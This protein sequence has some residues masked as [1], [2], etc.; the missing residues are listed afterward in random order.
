LNSTWNCQLIKRFGLVLACCALSLSVTG[1]SA[2]SGGPQAVPLP[3]PIAPPQD[4][5]YPGVIHLDV[6]ATDIDRHIFHVRQSLPVAAGERLTLMYPE[7]LAAK[8][9]DYG[10]VENLGGLKIYANDVRLAWTRD[11]VN[12]FAFQVDVPEGANELD[13]EFQFLSAVS[14]SQDRIVMTDE[15]LNLQ[16]PSVVLYPAGYFDRQL[17]VRSSIT[18]PEGWQLATALEVEESLK[19]VTKFKP[20]SLETLLD[21]PVYAGHYFKRLDLNPGGDVAVHLNIVADEAHLLEITPEQLQAHL[22]MVQQADKLFQSHHFDH[23]DFLFALTDRM[24]GIGLEHHQSSENSADPGYFTNWEANSRGRDLLPH[25]YT[26]SWNG[27]FRRPADLWTPN[28]SVPMRGSLLWVYEGQT[29]Y[30]G[31]VLAARSGLHTHLIRWLTLQRIT[32]F[33]LAEIGATC[34]TIRTIRLQSYDDHCRGQ[35]GSVLKTIIRKE[36]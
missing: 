8:H 27:K 25:E 33:R 18:V 19:N 2:Q 34:K 9:A 17:M 36:C 28:A 20:V 4:V 30:W 5:P 1:V 35:V 12:A 15:M 14:A 23:Y 31:K 11:P 22:A 32:T 13:L 26:H 16:W 7:W 10:R 24:G 3:E 21:S 29:Q 6:D